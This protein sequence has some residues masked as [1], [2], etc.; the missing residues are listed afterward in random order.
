MKIGDV[1]FS[2]RGGPQ[3]VEA[4]DPTNGKVTVNANAKDVDRSHRHG[5]LN[6]LEPEHREQFNEVMD[7]VRLARDPKERVEILQRR[8]LSLPQDST[9]R[10]VAKY[11]SAEMVHIMN[12][13]GVTPDRYVAY[14]TEI[15]A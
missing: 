4:R 7:E 9:G 10:V 5:Y 3:L 14:E 12:S 1:V 2:G 6:G 11:L 15:L 13:H 8:I